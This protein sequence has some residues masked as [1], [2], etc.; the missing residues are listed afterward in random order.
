MYWTNWL[1]GVVTV[2]EESYRRDDH[3][4]INYLL[5]AT[6]VELYQISPARRMDS[7]FLSLVI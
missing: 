6:N 7:K 4:V 3:I 5:G 2:C 1:E